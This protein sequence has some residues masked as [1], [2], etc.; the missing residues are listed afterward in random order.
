MSS[1][2][3]MSLFSLE[4]VFS[5]SFSLQDR[6]EHLLEDIG[7]PISQNYHRGTVVLAC[8]GMTILLDE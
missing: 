8:A 6:E 3:F 5:Q 2:Y 4:D 1:F 7:A